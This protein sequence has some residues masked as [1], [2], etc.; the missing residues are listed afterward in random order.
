MSRDALTTLADVQG[1][2]ET[3]VLD[4]V[5]RS[6][7]SELRAAIKNLADAREELDALPGQLPQEGRRLL[8]LCLEGVAALQALKIT[9]LAP[10]SLRCEQLGLRMQDDGA[11]LRE[12]IGAHAEALNLSSTLVVQL[13][14]GLRACAPDDARQAALRELLRRF[15]G[16]LQA[17]A[18]GRLRWQSVFPVS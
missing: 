16:E 3:Q 14:R 9:D 10:M 7:R 11:S 1:F 18:A 6:L 8:A 15:Y 5:P 17:Q 2:L 4:A 13:Q 12:R